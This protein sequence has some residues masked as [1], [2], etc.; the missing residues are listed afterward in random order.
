MATRSPSWAATPTPSD[1]SQEEAELTL[2]T[3][4]DD[5]ASPSPGEPPAEPLAE[6]P[7]EPPGECWEQAT[8]DPPLTLQ[9]TTEDCN[10]DNHHRLHRVGVAQK[11]VGLHFWSLLEAAGLTDIQLPTE[12]PECSDSFRVLAGAGRPG[13]V[14]PALGAML[15]CLTGR[16]P[17]DYQMYGCYCGQEGRG[18]PQ[19]PLDRC[20]LLHQCCLRQIST[21]GCRADRRLTAQVSCEGGSPRC[22]GVTACDKLQCVCDKTSADDESG[23]VKPRPPPF[24]PAPPPSR[25]A[26]P[27]SRPAPPP[28]R[29]APPPSR[30]PPHSAAAPSSG[31][32]PQRPPTPGGIQPHN[33]RPIRP[34]AGAP[35]RTPAPEEEEKGGEEEEEEE[36]EEDDR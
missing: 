21:M 6:P 2:T 17:Q 27:P 18:P 10:H 25:P 14:L 33:H 22:Q 19:D 36:E 35:E 13:R 28:S 20:C 3:P 15:R 9:L 30:P 12:G 32:W 34:S 8:V 4:S 16:C 23:E 11:R 1:A 5:L 29:P 26:P 31:E 7:G 24:R